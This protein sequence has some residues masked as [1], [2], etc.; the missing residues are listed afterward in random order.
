MIGTIAAESLYDKIFFDMPI[1]N[2]TI[3]FK[4]VNEPNDQ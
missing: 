3:S 1:K 4:I 2:K